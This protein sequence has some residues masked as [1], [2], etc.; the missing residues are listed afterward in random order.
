MFSIHLSGLAGFPGGSAV[1]N[2]PAIQVVWVWSLSWEDLLKEEM[3]T[4]SGILAWWILDQWSEQN[5][6]HHHLL[7]IPMSVWLWQPFP[8]SWIL[9]WLGTKPIFFC[10]WPQSGGSSLTKQSNPHPLKWRHGVLS[11]APPGKTQPA[12]CKASVFTGNLLF[13]NQTCSL[14]MI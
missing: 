8:D 4:H 1:K 13:Q 9:I 6:L 12:F 5:Y 10:F 2:L 11:T 3:A 14:P 7:I